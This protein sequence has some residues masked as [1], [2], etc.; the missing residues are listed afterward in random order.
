M[1]LMHIP[2]R[3]QSI[4][5]LVVQQVDLCESSGSHPFSQTYQPS[6]VIFSLHTLFSHFVMI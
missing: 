1:E 3:N 4:G 5:S 6:D 2:A